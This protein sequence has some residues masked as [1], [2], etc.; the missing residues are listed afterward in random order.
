MTSIKD[1]AKELKVSNIRVYQI[2]N[3]LQEADRPIKQGKKYILTDDNVSVIK[4]Y[5]RNTSYNLKKENKVEN[6][7]ELVKALQ[8]QVDNLNKQLSIKDKQIQT[9]DEQI[10]KLTTLTDQSQKLQLQTQSQLV[11][12]QKQIES[13]ANET[14]KASNDKDKG[15]S[16]PSHESKANNATKHWWQRL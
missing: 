9:K 14:S 13:K 2:I 5:F 11:N 10:D 12:A 4:K 7:L 1:L 16:Y 8:A 6:N 15:D 3:D